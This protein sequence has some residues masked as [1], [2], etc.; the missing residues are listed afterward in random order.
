MINKHFSVLIYFLSTILVLILSIFLYR[1]VTHISYTN[2]NDKISI[3]K[4]SDETI[5]N[6]DFN[7]YALKQSNTKFFY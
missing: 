7:I 6:S 5:S 2:L 1:L 4:Y 3:S